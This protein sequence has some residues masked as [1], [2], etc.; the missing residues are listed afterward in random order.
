MLKS[1]ADTARNLDDPDP[2]VR[3]RSAGLLRQ[4]AL[5]LEKLSP[6]EAEEAEAKKRRTRRRR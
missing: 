6:D 4:A 1:I 2:G 3:R 5:T